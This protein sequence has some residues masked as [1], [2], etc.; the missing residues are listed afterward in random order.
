MAEKIAVA[1][2]GPKKEKTFRDPVTRA[3]HV[4]PQFQKID[5]DSDL[6]YR[7]L[8]FKGVFV[9]GEDLKDAEKQQKA[10]AKQRADKEEQ[11]RL[12][13]E[14]AAKASQ[15]TVLVEG[16]LYDLNKMT[17]PKL[18]TLVESLG[19]EVPYNGEKKDDYAD[20]V[21]AAVLNKWPD[22]EVTGEPQIE[23]AQRQAETEAAQEEEPAKE[24]PKEEEKPA[25]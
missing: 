22:A 8:K 4:F 23:T 18:K 5:V 10:A 21:K 9:K 11:E 24:E 7:L 16:Q 1:Y 2:V 25:K 12:A 3:D 6:A 14:K 19:L 13:A 17:L 15:R 20:A